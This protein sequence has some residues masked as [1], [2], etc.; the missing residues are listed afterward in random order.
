MNSLKKNRFTLMEVVF[1][2]AV[3]ALALTAILPLI[4]V[5]LRA[6][7]D[8]IADNYVADTAEQFLHYMAAKC[9]ENW[10]ELDDITALKPGSLEQDISAWESNSI[11]E[12]NLFTSSD[13]DIFGIKQG[14]PNITDFTGVIRVWKSPVK[15]QIYSGSGW[16][17]QEDSSYDHSAGLNI[18]ISWPAE[19]PYA[20]REKKYFYL[21]IFKPN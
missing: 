17:E 6:T 2:L 19:I 11:N 10:S 16:D 13:K 3:V 7:K 1:A 4:A 5:G 21:E 9:K 18:E 15:S 12:T 8:S 14:S 20:Q